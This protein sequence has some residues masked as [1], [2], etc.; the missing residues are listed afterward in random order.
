[1][2]FLE[3]IAQNIWPVVS[4]NFSKPFR[5][6][7]CIL[8]AKAVK[9][10]LD[11]VCDI[12][13]NFKLASDNSQE[14]L[15]K[16]IIKPGNYVLMVSGGKDSAYL[17][18]RLNFEF[19]VKITP[20]L[21]DNGFMGPYA[22]KN[23]EHLCWTLGL[24]LIIL[25]QFKDRFYSAFKNAFLNLGKNPC[26]QYIDGVDGD[27]T[28]DIVSKYAREIGADGIISGLSKEQLS[29][30]FNIEND[31]KYID[32]NGMLNICP[33]AFWNTSET[34]IR[35][36]VMMYDLL[37]AA[38]P[39]STNSKLVLLMGIVDVKNLGY[40]SFEP[41]FA[42]LVRQGKADRQ[43]WVNMFDFLTWMVDHKVF[44][45]SANFTLSKFKLKLKDII[46]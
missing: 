30:I 33:L 4:K 46:K 13:K 38:G 41:E 3:L 16:L 20:V 9:I 12:C 31:Y 2:H 10:G 29:R 32:N 18:D 35:E 27:I 40:S 25:D 23:A 36:Y 19:N 6:T 34:T 43:Y 45:L 21:V 22:R 17:A 42:S 5:C 44:D 14:N 15:N 1:M 39:L 28:F 8:S 7:N 26:Y 11:G 24:D 37:E